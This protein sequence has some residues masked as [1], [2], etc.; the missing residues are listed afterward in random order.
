M[1]ARVSGGCCGGEMIGGQL[2]S[3]TKCKASVTWVHVPWINGKPFSRPISEIVTCDR[4]AEHVRE[5]GRRRYHYCKESGYTWPV[6]LEEL[7]QFQAR[8]HRGF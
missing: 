2:Y 6:A 8:G 3:P 7:S 4:R 1:G 5:K